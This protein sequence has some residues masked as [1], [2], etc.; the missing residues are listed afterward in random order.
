MKY[1]VQFNLKTNNCY[2]HILAFYP[3]LPDIS[4]KV[5]SPEK[6][7]E[8]ALEN[9]FI[10]VDDIKDCKKGDVFITEKPTHLMYYL[11]GQLVSH[12]PLNKL[13][14][15]EFLDGKMIVSIKYIVRRKE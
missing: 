2:H 3:H 5:L 4:Y 14:L 9:E 10:L 1:G 8:I 15:T 7:L 11:G 13:S 12:H 6:F